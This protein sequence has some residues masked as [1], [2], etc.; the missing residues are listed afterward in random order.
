[1]GLLLCPQLLEEHLSKMRESPLTTR[2]GP[3][4]LGPAQTPQRALSFQG[5]TI[6]FRGSISIHVMPRCV[7]SRIP[8]EF[9]SSNLFCYRAEKFDLFFLKGKN[10]S[11]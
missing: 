8:L 5:S 2:S 1:M 9:P 11:A 3:K 10:I 7:N 6:L 4:A